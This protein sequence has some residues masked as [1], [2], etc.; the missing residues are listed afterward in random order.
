MSADFK[1]EPQHEIETREPMSE[2]EIIKTLVDEFNSMFKRE[3]LEA[4]PYLIFKMNANL[5]IPVTAMYKDKRVSSICTNLAIIREALSKS[6]SITYNREKEIITPNIKPLKNKIILNKIPDL[7]KDK[8]FRAI[9]QSPEYIHKVSDKYIANLK[10][11]TLV[12]RNEKAA[13]SL[14]ETIKSVIFKDSQLEIKLG[15]EELYLDLLQKAQDTMKFQ[16]A[17]PEA[18]SNFPYDAYFQNY[19]YFYGMNSY[20]NQYMGMMGGPFG[21]YQRGN[22][23][24]QFYN[25]NYYD[26]MFIRKAQDDENEVEPQ[27]GEYHGRHDRKKDRF[28]KKSYNQRGPRGT[29]SDSK[30]HMSAEEI[31]KRTRVNSE[32]FPPLMTEDKPIEAPPKEE[33]VAEETEKSTKERL[34]YKKDDFVNIF[35][36]IASQVKP[37]E[38][39]FKF[40]ESQVP[41]LNL[42]TKPTIE[43]LETTSS[44][45]NS[46]SITRKIK[47][48]IKEKN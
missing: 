37:N 21:G 20:P 36:Q 2:E 29:Q 18:Q 30:N 25:N 39:L 11:Y 10:S 26:Q 4:N 22:Y 31:K 34:R 16:S 33:V 47:E 44:R 43:F 40:S 46:E 3:N 28:S 14:V 9:Y 24:N 32:N 1:D 5:E 41:V 19:G 15:F 7:E 17:H 27:R 12:L 38:R 45:K 35:K 48:E 8:I 23:N 6:T 42:K 13:E